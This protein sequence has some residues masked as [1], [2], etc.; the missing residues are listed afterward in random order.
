MENFGLSDG[1]YTIYFF[2]TVALI[3]DYVYASF[4]RVQA[5]FGFVNHILSFVYAQK[6]SIFLIAGKKDPTGMESDYLSTVL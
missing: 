3:W 5:Y 2:A 4:S 1:C 6:K